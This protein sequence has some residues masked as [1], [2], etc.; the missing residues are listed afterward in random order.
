MIRVSVLYPNNSGSTFDMDYYVSKHIPLVQQKLGVALKAVT[1]DQ[2]LS[3]GQPGSEAAY[4]AIGVLL[5]DSVEAFERAFTPHAA[6]IMA[7]I[8]KYTNIAPIMQISE[9]K[10]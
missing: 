6:E 10:M 9:V 3:G 7:D 5:L 8:P 1:V 2:G 4:R